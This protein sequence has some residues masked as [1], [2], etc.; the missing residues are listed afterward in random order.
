MALEETQACHTFAQFL[1]EAENGDLHADLSKAIR[2]LIA[3]LHDHAANTSGKAAGELS[4]KIKFKLDDAVV[5]VD[6]DT[7]V[8]GVSQIHFVTISN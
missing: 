4:L 7:A 2:D 6:D 5:N 1:Q 3:K 8:D